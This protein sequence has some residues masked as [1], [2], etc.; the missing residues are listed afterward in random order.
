[1]QIKS[2]YTI[3]ALCM[4]FTSYFNLN[5]FGVNISERVTETKIDDVL[6]MA[7]F[8][9]LKKEQSMEHFLKI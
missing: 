8:S 5:V 4:I 7:N 1:M 9:I 3:L 6:S 2:I